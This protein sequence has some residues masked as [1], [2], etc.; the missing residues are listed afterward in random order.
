MQTKTK[1]TSVDSIKKE[2]AMKFEIKDNT[3]CPE[4]T[5]NSHIHCSFTQG[6]KYFIQVNNKWGLKEYSPYRLIDS[7]KSKIIACHNTNIKMNF[8]EIYKSP[9]NALYDTCC[10]MTSLNQGCRDKEYP[11]H[12]VNQIY[13]LKYQFS[14]IL[15]QEHKCIGAIRQKDKNNPSVYLIWFFFDIEGNKFDWHIPEEDVPFLFII[16]RYLP[17]IRSSSWD[18]NMSFDMQRALIRWVINNWNKYNK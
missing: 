13:Y 8:M 11:L 10:C 14:K 18:N 4:I 6:T 12:I 5:I 16:S 15:Y 17:S 9:R 2:T 3:K 1:V 7:N